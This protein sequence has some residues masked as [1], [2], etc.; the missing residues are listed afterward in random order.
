MLSLV[1]RLFAISIVQAI[2]GTLTGVLA[3]R[4]LGPEGRG[5]LAAVLVP[6]ALAPYALAFGATTFAGRAAARREPVPVLVGTLGIFALAV[7]LAA[8]VPGWFAASALAGGNNEVRNLLVLGVVLLPLTL[9]GSVLTNIAMGLERWRAI[10]VQRLI[11]IG[12]SVV[13]YVG[14]AIVGQLTVTTAVLVILT[15]GL[16]AMLPLLG[17]LRAGLPPRFSVATLRAAIRFG[18]RSTPITVSQLLNQRLDQLVMVPL[19]S[20]RELGIYAVAVTL[21]G[22]VGMLSSAIATALFPRMV[23]GG[24]SYD[25]ALAVRRGLL[26][27]I[28]VAAPMTVLVP[29]VLPL[30]FGPEFRD[31]VP[32]ALVLLVAAV[33][34]AGAHYLEPAFIANDAIGMLGASEMITLSVTVVGLL[35]FVAT[36]GAMAAAC[37]SLAAYSCNFSILVA[38]APRRFGGRRLDYAMPTYAEVSAVVSMLRR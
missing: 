24:G 37:V 35:V 21:A 27:A 33:P 5:S 31:A 15:G 28:T 1:R 22:V 14:L 12:I 11:P 18:V 10:T 2:A 17:T 3:A 16:L 30:L 20:A 36:G 23:K 9:V 32:V 34:A 6:L 4:A 29:F 7:G 38:L 13:G 26:A 19:V 25:I 8:I